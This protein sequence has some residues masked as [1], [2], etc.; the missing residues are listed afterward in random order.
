MCAIIAATTAIGVLLSADKKKRAQVF[1]ELYEFNERMLIN[2]KFGKARMS[3]IAVDFRYIPDILAG[4]S[5]LNGSDGQ[6][7]ADYIKNIGVSDSSSQI[8]YLNERKATIKKLMEESGENYKKYSSLYIKI[9]L[10]TG[11]LIAVLLA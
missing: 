3:Q 2:L 5:V 10:M 8:D 6:F 11:I 4:K 9:A 7:I 1:A